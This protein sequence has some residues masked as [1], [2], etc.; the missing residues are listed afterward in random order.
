MGWDDNGL[1]T[2]RRVQNYFGVRCDP[3]LPYDP[4][5][6]A[7][8]RARPRPAAR[9]PCSPAATSSSCATRLTAEDEKAFEDAVAPARPVGRLDLHLHHDRRPGA[10]G[11]AQRAF[12]RNLARGE[13]YQAE[14]PT[15][16]DVDFR[17]RRRPGRARGPRAA[18][19]LP[20]HRVPRGRRRRPVCHRDHPARAAPRLRRAG[21]PPR[22]RALPAAVRHHVRTP[23][24]RRRGAGPRPPAGRAR[25]GHRHRHDLHVRRHHRRHLVAR[26]A[27]CPPAPSS[28]ANGRS[29][30]RRPRRRSPTR[31][32]RRAYAEL[33]GKTV[34]QAQARIVELLRE[35]GRARRASPSRSPTRSSSTRRA[36]RPLE[37]VTS[38]QWYIRNGGRDADLR[39]A[40]LARGRGAALAPAATCGPRYENWVDGLNGDW[41]ISRQRFFGVPVPGLVP[42]RRRRRARLRRA[43]SCPTRPPCPSTRPSDVPARLRRGPARPAGRLRRRPRHHGHLGHVVAHAADR[44]RLGATTPT[45]SSAPSRWTC[46]RRP[47]RSS[48]PG[49]SP[50]WCAPTSSTTRCRGAT[51]PSR[52]GSSTPTARRCRS[53]RA[54]WS[55]RWPCSTSTAPTPCATGRPA[56]GPGTDTA[57]DE[58]QMKVGRRLAIKLLN[59]QQ[60]RARPGRRRRPPV[61]T[62]ADHRAARPGDA[63]RPGR[64]S[65]TRPPPPFEGYDYARALERTEAFFWAFC[66]DYLELV[67]GRAYGAG[68]ARAGVGPGRAALALSTLLRL[69]APFL[70]FVTEE[71][72]SWW[73]EGSI[74]RAAWP[75]AD[76][77][78]TLA[79]DG[80]PLV[81]EVAGEVLGE[82][83]KAKTEAK[84]SMRAEVASVVVRDTPERLAALAL[85]AGRRQGSRWG[86]RPRDPRGRIT[87]SWSRSTLAPHHRRPRL[88]GRRSPPGPDSPLS[89]G[90]KFETGSAVGRGSRSRQT[91]R[92]SFIRMRQLPHHLELLAGAGLEDE[93][94]CRRCPPP[95]P[96]RPRAPAPRGAPPFPTP[97]RATDLVGTRP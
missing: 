17:H 60:V 47:T 59:A 75:D 14:A 70:P 69:F 7:A 67:K 25:Q 26:A 28:A 78:G 96:R 84:V 88:A 90:S 3:S 31:R 35:A 53:R 39:E 61:T 34:N 6:R 22:R 79:G 27:T 85:A 82:I 50:P 83:R 21:G 64:R 36:T 94:D 89:G 38:R 65:S 18:R 33:A 40:L 97:R 58:G 37:I 43:R 52:A 9:S 63:R 13:A 1:P 86:G 73:Q 77:S 5:F 92:A 57:F 66:D 76:E 44:R 15:L 72:W 12:L 71:V 81:S 16:W 23:A 62:A 49:C 24:V 41:L 30:R 95:A 4:D 11:S 68:A 42:A 10:G 91:S 80:D 93:T 46:A 20:P 54:T 29:A 48:A 19:R 55:R 2:E 8:G 56:A 51:P 74:H 87:W 32:T 45:C